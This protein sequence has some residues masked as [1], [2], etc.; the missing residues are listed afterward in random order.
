MQEYEY[1]FK[2]DSVESTIK[3]CEQN[4]YKK[5]FEA[6]QNRVVF[7]NESNRNI[8]ARITTTDLGERS[9]IKFDVKHIKGSRE[10]LKVSNESL[11]LVLNEDNKQSVLSVLEVL[12]FV[13][14]ADNLR[15][16]CVYE[17]D[18]VRF[19][20]DDYE[21]PPMC[22]IAIEGEKDSVNQECKILKEKGI[23]T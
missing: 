5:V 9:D 19:E 15:T 14:V 18:S 10:N 6:S 11:P 23:I 2:V 7:E 1:S 8:I 17:K 16:R 12:G 3:Y 20:I 21:S 4:G 22:V 13:E